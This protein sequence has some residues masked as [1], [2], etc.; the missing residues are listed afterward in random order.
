M[1]KNYILTVSMLKVLH[2]V[3]SSKLFFFLT[4]NKLNRNPKWVSY[5]WQHK[6][7]HITSQGV[8]V[9][10]MLIFLVHKTEQKLNDSFIFFFFF[11][12]VILTPL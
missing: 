8:L 4:L 9:R 11:S 1:A 12:F 3:K 5:W 6:S 2:P 10:D 7:L